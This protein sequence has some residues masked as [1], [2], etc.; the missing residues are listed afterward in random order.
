MGENFVIEIIILVM[1]V[2]NWCPRPRP[3]VINW[4]YFEAGACYFCF[5]YPSLVLLS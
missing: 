4:N 2:S 3:Q 1:H 5:A